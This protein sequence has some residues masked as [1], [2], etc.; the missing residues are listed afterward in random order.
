MAYSDYIHCSNCGEKA[1]YWDQWDYIGCSHCEGDI[2]RAERGVV[3]VYC[4]ECT[5]ERNPTPAGEPLAKKSKSIPFTTGYDWDQGIHT[6]QQGRVTVEFPADDPDEVKVRTGQ[7]H[8]ASIPR[9]AW[10]F[11]RRQLLEATHVHA[12][13]KKADSD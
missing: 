12:T 4:P 3:E 2:E 7:F 10:E 8:G 1:L 11:V 5:A 9:H 13:G 6:A